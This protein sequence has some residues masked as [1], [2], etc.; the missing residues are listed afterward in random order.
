[1]KLKK[2]IIT[3]LTTLALSPVATTFG[4]GLLSATQVVHADTITDV[5]KTTAIKE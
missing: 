2:T 5:Q 4:N 1:M 3:G